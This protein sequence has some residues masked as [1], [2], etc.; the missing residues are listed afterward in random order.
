LFTDSSISD[1]LERVFFEI[2]ANPHLDNAKPFSNITSHSYFPNEEEV[3]FM[4]GSIFKLLSIKKTD[5][6]G[7]W[8]IRMT[9]C[10]DDDYQL[11]PVFDHMKNEYSNEKTN[12]LLFGHILTGMGK[13]DDAEKY[14]HRLLSKLSDDNQEVASRY[15][16]LGMIANKKGDYEASLK[17]YNKSLMIDMRTLKSNHPDLAITY[18]SIGET[19]RKIGDYKNASESFDK[20]LM[21]LKQKLGD[22]HLDT[23]RC[24]INL[25]N[26]YQEK[27]KYLNALK[28]Y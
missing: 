3:L 11:K 16:A 28:L 21:I 19:Y 22:D 5:D 26:I 23:A 17:W 15:H 7:I 9:L 13:L 18:S 6:N 12:L 10:S 24:F 4:L 2:E 14:Y 8:I 25:G 27:K 20:A 1:D